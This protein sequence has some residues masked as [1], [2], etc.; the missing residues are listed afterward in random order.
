[1]HTG[2]LGILVS[3]EYNLHF[4]SIYM[5]YLLSIVNRTIDIWSVFIYFSFVYKGKHMHFLHAKK[6]RT[7]KYS[8]HLYSFCVCREF[9]VMGMCSRRKD[10]KIPL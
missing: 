10:L 1:M 4:I 6:Q 3:F 7:V 9:V 8:G 5:F 2:I